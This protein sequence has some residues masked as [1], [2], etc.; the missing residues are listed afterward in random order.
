M[1]PDSA[2]GL[3]VAYVDYTAS[4]ANIYVQHLDSLGFLGGEPDDPDCEELAGY[5]PS[6]D[7]FSWPNGATWMWPNPLLPWPTPF[8]WNSVFG[9]SWGSAR[10][11]WATLKK[12]ERKW[13]GSCD[14]F[15]C[16]AL[17][18][19]EGDLNPSTY[20]ASTVN[21]ILLDDDIRDLINQNQLIQYGNPVLKRYVDQLYG[22][23]DPTPIVERLFNNMDSTYVLSIKGSHGAHSIVPYDV[24][25]GPFGTY[26]I[27]VYDCNLPNRDDIYIQYDPTFEYWYHSDDPRFSFT[28]HGLFIK[29]IEL[30]QKQPTLPIE[31]GGPV[32]DYH[33]VIPTEGAKLGIYDEDEDAFCGF[34][35]DSTINEFDNYG[36]LFFPGED[37]L[38]WSEAFF[39]VPNHSLNISLSGVSNTVPTYDFCILRGDKMITFLDIEHSAAT[40]SEKVVLSDTSGQIVFS[41]NE[42]DRDFSFE[43]ITMGPMETQLLCQSTGLKADNS[44]EHIIEWI[45]STRQVKVKNTTAITDTYDIRVGIMIGDARDSSVATVNIVELRDNE[46]QRIEVDDWFGDTTSAPI[47]IRIHRD[48]ESDDVIDVVIDTVVEWMPFDTTGIEEHGSLP[49][50]LE[51]YAY[52][53]PFNSAVSIISPANATVEIFDL[54]GRSVA[55]LPGGDQIWKPEAS[56]GSGVYLVRAK[57]GDKEVTKRVVYLK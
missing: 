32:P 2:N 50:E 57:V 46:T 5:L 11:Y 29:P 27:Y 37:S 47:H 12:C 8:M 15:S 39:I 51:L 49:Q 40:D 38:D 6:E 25:L 3:I 10:Y 41:T 7:G 56:V 23:H 55:Q 52:P 20:G 21:D 13:G 54:N 17:L 24:C 53:N 28:E 43:I 18:F 4:D 45:D 14:G 1:L 22:P 35:G 30:Y 36:P 31:Y 44:G 9:L 34:S 48:F 33:I 16:T 26:K 42:D 19:Y